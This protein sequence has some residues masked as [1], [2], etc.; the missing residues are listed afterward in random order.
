MVERFPRALEPMARAAIKG[1]VRGAQVAWPL[2]RRLPSDSTHFGPPRNF[3]ESF[4]LWA[5]SRP[6]VTRRV[7]DEAKDFELDPPLDPSPNAPRWFYD[8]RHRQGFETW[9]AR[10]PGGRLVGSS[11]TVVGPDDTVFQDLHNLWPRTIGHQELTT[12]VRLP[13]VQHVSGSVA[14]AAAFMGG[15]YTHWLLDVVP[16]LRLLG[17]DLRRVDHLVVQHGKSFQRD[18]LE[19]AGAPMDR[20]I[21][22][23]QD[24]H[25]VAEEL[26]L[27]SLVPR[28]QRINID[29]VQG[30]FADHRST[31]PPHRRLYLTRSN[32]WR[33]RL[34]NE[35]ELIAAL[36]PRG[37]ET[38]IMDGMSVA[39]QSRMFSEAKVI[40]G[41][42]GSALANMI[43]AQP[44]SVMI[45]MF[46]ENY[47]HPSDWE[48]AVVTGGSYHVLVSPSTQTRSQWRDIQAS[49][50]DVLRALDVHAIM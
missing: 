9:V 23:T 13:R 33:R 3:V 14:V 41:P 31:A 39:E 37:F 46:D 26:V 36:G 43:W 1:R 48:L 44:D 2:L 10:V 18:C 28:A 6:E 30:L 11:P 22:P 49:V 5:S 16:R 25:L 35:A 19:A 15:N 21:E 17:D 40:I 4:Q 34:A 47:T 32:M 24:M 45:E 29:Y 7:V 38:V 12:R 8:L 27:P 50:P 42:N 20:L